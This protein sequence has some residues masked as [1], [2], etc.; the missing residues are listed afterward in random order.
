MIVQ[1]GHSVCAQP[2]RRGESQAVPLAKCTPDVPC[3]P[4]R[5]PTPSRSLA[6]TRCTRDVVK[7]ENFQIP[8]E[9][10]APSPITSVR[11]TPRSRLLPTPRSP[12]SWAPPA[13]RNEKVTAPAA[14]LVATPVKSWNPHPVAQ[15]VQ[16]KPDEVYTNMTNMTRARPQATQVTSW[17]P[18]SAPRHEV[19]GPKS[20]VPPVAALSYA[21]PSGRNAASQASHRMQ[22]AMNA[23]NAM[24][25]VHMAPRAAQ[26]AQSAQAPSYKGLSDRS[27]VPCLS[28]VS[29]CPSVVDQRGLPGCQTMIA[30]PYQEVPTSQ[31]SRGVF[32]SCQSIV[33]P[34]YAAGP[35]SLQIASA[36]RSRQHP[37][38]MNTGIPNA[39][40][41]LEGID[42]VGIADGVSGVHSLGLTPDALPWE[43]LRSC[44]RGLFAAAAKGEP[45]VRK[46]KHGKMQ[47]MSDWLIQLIQEAF[48][49]T[50]EY[51]A[52]TLLL[53]AIKGS[54]LVTACLGDSGIL[55]LRPVAF[56]PLRLQPIFKT[57]PG[58]FDARRPVQI[59]R[60][61]G[62]DVASAHEVISSANIGTTSVRPGDFLILGTDGL[63][64]NLSDK[65]I[66]ET[67]ERFYHSR[68]ATGSN[69]ELGE[70]A[71]LLVDFAIRSVK[72][73]KDNAAL[74][75]WNNSATVPANNADDTTALVAMIKA[76]GSE[77]L[78][79][80]RETCLHRHTHTHTYIYIYIYVYLC[81]N[82]H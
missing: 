63:F 64:D 53:A 18:P 58:R 77:G 22:N 3:L 10:T 82:R 5:V 50:E 24:N 40:A 14:P 30:E 16:D 47:Q 49:S 43:L 4:L 75:P 57:E 13:T 17:V 20:W 67:L 60:L 12:C 7:M 8:S 45:R 46:V 68:D 44:G 41:V 76:E 51:G 33:A 19:C 6:A 81:L 29:Y 35:Q 42:Y 26:F 66:K 71:S 65:Q 15:I 70:V 38:K 28:Q 27:F 56:F 37:V 48:D 61:H 23:M 25:A 9:A 55:I 80:L 11:C 72:L 54:D 34:V 79:T 1:Q 59:Q 21:P 62:C 69:E 32:P 74:P 73:S 78:H 31:G 2:V 36:F 52:T 39:D